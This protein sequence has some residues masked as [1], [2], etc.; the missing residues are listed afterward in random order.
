MYKLLS[1]SALGVLITL[2]L[3]SFSLTTTKPRFDATVSVPQTQN[4]T[5]I[6]A[7]LTGPADPAVLKL[8]QGYDA[9]RDFGRSECLNG[10]ISFAGTPNGGLSVRQEMS[11]AE[12]QQTIGRMTKAGIKGTIGGKAFDVSNAASFA[13]NAKTSSTSFSSISATKFQLKNAIFT[14]LDSF[15]VLEEL[16]KWYLANGGTRNTSKL[17]GVTIPGLNT[18]F[19]GSLKSPNVDEFTIGFGAQIGSRGFIRADYIDKT[20]ND[21]YSVSISPKDQIE[22]PVIAGEFLD[23]KVT[24]NT[25]DLVKEYKAVQTQASYRAFNRVNLGLSYTWSEATG[26]EI[27]ETAGSGPSASVPNSYREYKAFAQNN[28]PRLPAERPDAPGSP[29]GLV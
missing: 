13:R 5:G 22:N 16:F 25:N 24:E 17:V 3:S 19:D 27:G 11:E 18:R 26:N 8:G 9:Q 4:T 28:P 12:L 15:G 29:L 14:K 21:F 2:P 6:T 20:W 1:A 7:T 10:S 23:F